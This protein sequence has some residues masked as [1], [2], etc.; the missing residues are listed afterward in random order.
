MARRRRADAYVSASQT[1]PSGA[2]GNSQD[3][4]RA[5]GHRGHNHACMQATCTGRAAEG[6]SL[7]LARLSLHLR[8]SPAW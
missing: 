5:Y 8:D 4:R 7:G 2:R 3:L 1:L 6:A